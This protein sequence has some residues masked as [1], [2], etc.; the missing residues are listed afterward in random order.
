MSL[1]QPPEW[2]PGR[3]DVPTFIASF[4]LGPAAVLNPQRPHV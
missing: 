2:E 1:P 4:A 3:T